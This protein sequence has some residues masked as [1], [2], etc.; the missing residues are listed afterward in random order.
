MGS[1]RVQASSSLAPEP[2]GPAGHREE[3]GMHGLAAQP[4][5]VAQD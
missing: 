1:G 2:S 3:P 5:G 4:D